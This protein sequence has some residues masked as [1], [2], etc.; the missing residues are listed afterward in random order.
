MRDKLKLLNDNLLMFQKYDGKD[1]AL[2]SIL[3][4]VNHFISSQNFNHQGFSEL[5]QNN[6]GVQLQNPFTLI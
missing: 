5:S 4:S 1:V 3:E 6:L 2:T